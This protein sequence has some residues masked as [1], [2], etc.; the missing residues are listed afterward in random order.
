MY[1][2]VFFILSVNERLTTLCLGGALCTGREW[3]GASRAAAGGDRVAA[4][5]S[6]RYSTRSD[7]G[8]GGQGPRATTYASCASHTFASCTTTVTTVA[9][10][11]FNVVKRL[12]YYN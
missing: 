8:L 12:V 2:N 11:E 7:P 6:E 1:L 3:S 5:C 9:D 10:N 4:K